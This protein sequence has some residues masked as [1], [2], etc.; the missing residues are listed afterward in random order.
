MYHTG[1][2]ECVTL[3]LAFGS[4]F[5]YGAGVAM[6]QRAA[7]E[8]P[9]QQA[10]RPGLLVR[11]VQRP[12]WLLGM[13]AELGGFALQAA[14]LQRGSLVVV[15]PV[16]TASLAFTL[17]IGSAWTH[18]RLRPQEWVGVAGVLV[19]ITIFLVVAGPS[20]ASAG[21]ATAHEW[22]ACAVAIVVAVSLAM[23]AAVRAIGPRR[24]ALFGVAAGLADAFMAVLVKAF[25]ARLEHG[26]GATMISWQPYALAGGG[27]AALLLVQSAYQAGFP[28]ISLPI[29][30]VVDPVVSVV[31]GLSI[32]GEH[33]ALNGS[34]S[35]AIVAALAS[36]AAGLSLLARSPVVAEPVR[37]TT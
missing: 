24:A 7:V 13:A 11:L 26:L 15:Q 37:K 32:F 12:I 14:A 29:I 1:E 33:L 2:T 36:A 35:V 34:R 20:E 28:T 18:R 10:L 23:L 19:G 22:L 8:A 9:V 17:V 4:S 27:L 6:Q 3:L 25:A 16:L 21:T 5:L 30:N 31:I